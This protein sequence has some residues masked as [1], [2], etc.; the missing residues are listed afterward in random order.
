V[1]SFSIS[2]VVTFQLSFA[3][4]EAG[5]KLLSWV[6]SDYSGRR[7]VILTTNVELGQWNTVINANRFAAA[8][9]NRII[10]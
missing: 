10:H 2:T 6:I 9:I 5:S 1:V 7:N 3:L 4:E 8:F